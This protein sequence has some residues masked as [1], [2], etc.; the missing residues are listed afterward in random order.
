MDPYISY[1]KEGKILD[2]KSEAQKLK[3]KASRFLIID[4]ELYQKPFGGPLLLCVT[5][6]KRKEVLSEINERQAGN[7]RGK[8]FTTQS[9][10]AMLLLANIEI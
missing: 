8:S 5:K 10:K 9:S 3:M 4:D 1:V 2:D 7:F 6:K